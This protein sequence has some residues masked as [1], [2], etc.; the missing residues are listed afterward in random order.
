MVTKIAI[1]LPSVLHLFPIS[2]MALAATKVTTRRQRA[3]T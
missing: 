2:L 1:S 3:A